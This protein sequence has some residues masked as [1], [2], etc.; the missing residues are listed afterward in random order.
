MCVFTGYALYEEY[1]RNNE[2]GTA[3]PHS[4]KLFSLKLCNVEKYLKI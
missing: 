1:L 2:V 3:A 4:T